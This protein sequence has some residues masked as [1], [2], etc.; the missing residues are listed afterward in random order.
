MRILAINTDWSN[1]YRKKFNKYGGIGYYRLV[2]PLEGLDVD[3]IGSN[4]ESKLDMTN[5]E[6]LYQSYIDLVSGYDVVITKQLDTPRAINSL[7]MACN[8][9]QVPLIMDIDDNFMEVTESQPAYKNGY[10]PGGMKKAYAMTALSFADA[11]FV[12]TQPL[13]DYFKELLEATV[14]HSDTIHVLPNANDVND[15]KFISPKNTKKVVIGWHGS[16]THDKDLALVLPAIN[17]LMNEYP[18]LY[19]ELLG[20]VTESTLKYFNVFDVV[21]LDRVRTIGGTQAWEGF[22]QLVMAQKWDIGIAPLENNE[23]NCGKSHIKW[24]ELAMKEIPVVASN[25]YPY[26]EAINGVPVIQDGVTGFLVDEDWYTPLKKLID[27]IELRE[28]VGKAGKET[29]LNN[30]Q[31][32]YFRED[33]ISAIKEVISSY[34]KK[35]I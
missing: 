32:K 14:G 18:N 27:N 5:E 10:N 4:L 11:V 20:G 23:F 15:W 30:W 35:Q 28:T 16:V 21:N 1:E 33:W 17:Q 3:Y 19:L 8:E 29:I 13:K 7:L 9:A 2:K 25:V 12:S 34:T 31:Y 26:K 24:M 6:T 22:P